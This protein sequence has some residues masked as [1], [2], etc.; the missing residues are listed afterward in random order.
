MSLEQKM[1]LLVES[2]DRNTA[3]VLA[4]RGL[5]AQASEPA[6]EI[7]EETEAAP[8]TAAAPAKRGPGR[9][10]KAKPLTLDDCKEVA[11]EVKEKLGTD[12]AKALIAQHGASSLQKLDPKNFAAFIADCKKS[13]AA[14]P[15]ADDGEA[16]EDL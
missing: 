10:P 8:K 9:P 4:A 1:Q 7:A 6:E 12:A 16:E 14:A 11:F 5:N 3:A 2:L 15:A 13:L